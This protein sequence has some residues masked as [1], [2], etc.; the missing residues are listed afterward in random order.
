MALSRRNVIGLFVAD[1]VIFVLSNVVTET[2]A[3]PGTAS[4]IL[5]VVFLIGFVALIVLCVVA[6]VQSMRSRRVSA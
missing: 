4:N 3:H 5:W 6:G 1:V 2:N